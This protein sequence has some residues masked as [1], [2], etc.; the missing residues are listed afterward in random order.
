MSRGEDGY[1]L[2]NSPKKKFWAA[3]HGLNLRTKDNT[4]KQICSSEERRTYE[5]NFLQVIYDTTLQK[6]LIC[7][8]PVNKKWQVVEGD[9]IE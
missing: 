1:V 2:T 5:P 4:Q 9:V 3:G 6:L 8:D 7:I